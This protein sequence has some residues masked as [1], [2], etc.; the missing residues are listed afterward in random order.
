MPEG[1][2]LQS[3]EQQNRLIT[4]QIRTEVDHELRKARAHMA[5]EP[6][7]V[8]QNLKVM[9]ERVAQAPELVAE[10][11]AQLRGQLETALREASRRAATKEILDQELQETKA[12]ALDRLRIADALVRDQERMKQLVDRFESLMD[13]GRYAAAD[14]LGATEIP[15]VAPNNPI[16][17][18]TAT[19]AH[20]VGTRAANLA[21][22][23]ARAK[24][25][26]D[27]LATVEIS[28]IPFP[29]DQ[30]VVYPDAAAWEELTL[31]RTK[32]R[33]V[34]LKKFSPAE[35]K[36]R[37]TLKKET[38]IPAYSGASLQDV[39]DDLKDRLGIEIQLDVEHLKEDLPIS[40]DAVELPEV[41]GMS[42]RAYL[43]LM[44]K[45]L[46]GLAY[47]IQ[48]DMLLLTTKE[49]AES[50]DNLVRKVYPVGDLVVPI[51]SSGM[52]A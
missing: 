36:I 46:P 1:A 10:V 19:M 28:F 23:N 51:M 38:S 45:R 42:F 3:I 7:Q 21:Q 50:E 47:L 39:A 11:R 41:K 17:S 20:L 15:E 5:G 37:E 44:K 33:S 29:D 22:R 26:V 2:L 34:D 4:A 32:Y 18:T 49:V 6:L 27:T 8:E 40:I 14:E 9:L 25:V 48:D 12:A 24:A 16:S 31:R 35:E 30:P 13:E 52:A 43:G